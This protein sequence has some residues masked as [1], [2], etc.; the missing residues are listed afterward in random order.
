MRSTFLSMWS[1]ASL[2]LGIFKKIRNTSNF[3]HSFI[4]QGMGHSV[5]NRHRAFIYVEWDHIESL[6]LLK[7][8]P[9]NIISV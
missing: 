9:C 5:V 3:L 6:T 7:S 2:M 1:T 4:L 8:L